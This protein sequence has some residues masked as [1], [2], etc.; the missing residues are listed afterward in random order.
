MLKTA[1]AEMK[2][3]KR[4]KR[5]VGMKLTEEIED[6]QHLETSFCSKK[7][8]RIS[9][10][11]KKAATEASMRVMNTI[12][13]VLIKIVK[14]Q[15]GSRI[16]YS[17]TAAQVIKGRPMMSVFPQCTDCACCPLRH[18]TFTFVVSNA[19]RVIQKCFY[20]H[21]LHQHKSYF[22]VMFFFPAYYI[23][24]SINVADILGMLIGNLIKS[25][26]TITSTI[27]VYYTSY[28]NICRNM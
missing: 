9:R 18:V 7:E 14:C 28:T 4:V 26:D 23:A 10:R 27:S 20:V 17:T 3:E 13:L 25:F 6:H 19:R 24:L 8:I 22:H 11:K 1:D 2:R 16:H 15:S 5:T 21:I 12:N